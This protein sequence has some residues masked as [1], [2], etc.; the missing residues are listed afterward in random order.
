MLHTVLRRGRLD[1]IDYDTRDRTFDKIVPLAYQVIAILMNYERTVKDFGRCKGKAGT[2]YGFSYISSCVESGF[3]GPCSNSAF[4]VPCGDGEC[5]ATYVDCL[6]SVAEIEAR[7]R[8]DAVE[9]HD[10]DNVRQLEADLEQQA[11]GKRIVGDEWTFNKDG[12]VT[13]EKKTFV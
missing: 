9:G 12:P 1:Y 11:T 4:P 5:K 8:T 10:E 6:R 2:E 13:G 7:R 3:K